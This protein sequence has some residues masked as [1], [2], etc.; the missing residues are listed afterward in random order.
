MQ[1]CYSKSKHGC[2]K[3][4]CSNGNTG[5]E[6]ILPL[7]EELRER[8]AILQTGHVKIALNKGSSG[9]FYEENYWRHLLFGRDYC[10]G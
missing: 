8:F 6:R 7:R 2:S 9:I 3:S 10:G 1:E 4:D 5:R